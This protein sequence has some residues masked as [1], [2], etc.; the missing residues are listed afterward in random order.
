MSAATL[1]IHPLPYLI[2]P[3]SYILSIFWSTYPWSLLIFAL[4]F[5]SEVITVMKKIEKGLKWVVTGLC[6]IR[7]SR[8]MTIFTFHC[9]GNPAVQPS[10]APGRSV[11][12]VKVFLEVRPP[13]FFLSNNN[14]FQDS[15]NFLNKKRRTV[16]F[17]TFDEDRFTARDN[18]NMKLLP[19]SFRYR[20]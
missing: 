20:S 10:G 3:L 18:F 2:R 7:Q 9:Q 15:F 16:Q 8:V 17:V 1:L 6:S 4:I 5:W 14:C 11:Q 12:P 13:Q 19:I